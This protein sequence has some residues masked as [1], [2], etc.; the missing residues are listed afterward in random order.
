MEKAFKES[1]VIKWGCIGREYKKEQHKKEQRQRAK[2]ERDR[3]QDN[4]EVEEA[5]IKSIGR[6]KIEYKWIGYRESAWI[7]SMN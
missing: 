1:D 2:S 5:Y 7:E 4:K 6:D 3:E